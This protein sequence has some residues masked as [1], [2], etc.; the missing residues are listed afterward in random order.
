MLIDHVCR[1]CG[2]T[3]LN[4]SR[5]RNPIEKIAGPF[6]PIY[7]CFCCNLRQAKLWFVKV[8]HYRS[9]QKATYEARW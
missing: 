3:N 6:L 5:A 2:S 1:K 9:M 7:R 8:G 4:R